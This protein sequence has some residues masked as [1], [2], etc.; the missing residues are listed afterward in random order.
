[1]LRPF[2]EADDGTEIHLRAEGPHFALTREGKT[3]ESPRTPSVVSRPCEPKP[4]NRTSAYFFNDERFFAHRF[5]FSRL[6]LR[7]RRCFRASFRLAPCFSN[8][9]CDLPENKTRDASDQLLP[10]ERFTCTRT[11]CVPSSLRDFRRVDTP[12]SL[13]LGADYRGTECFTTLENASAD[14][15]WTR[16]AILPLCP[17][18]RLATA[19]VSSER[20]RFLPT[21]PAN[22]S[23]L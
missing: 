2:R 4:A 6:V 9:S 12:P 16:A 23:S 5:A 15:R 22:R 11:S 17:P 21:A 14:R 7:V 10:P 13:G 1:M 19:Y 18:Y 3:G 8:R 20:G